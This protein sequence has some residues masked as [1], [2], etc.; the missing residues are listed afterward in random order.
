MKNTFFLSAFVCLGIL[1]AH[2]Q[3]MGRVCSSASLA[4][5]N[6]NIYVPDTGWGTVTDA[7]GEYDLGKIALL[8]DVDTIRF[9]CVGYIGC[10]V[11]LEKLRQDNFVTVLYE[12]TIALH[13]VPVTAD[14]HLQS[15]LA[16]ER[17]ASVPGRGIGA[18]GSCLVGGKI[19]VTGGDETNA[20]VPAPDNP[21]RTGYKRPAFVYEGYNKNMYIY[22]IEKDE[23]MKSPVQFRPRAYH[24]LL[25]YR[26]R[27]YLVGGKSLSTN[28][29]IEWLNNTID[30]YDWK[31]DTLVVDDANPHQAANAAAFIYGDQMIVMG[32]SIKKTASERLYYTDDIHVLDLK[33]GRWYLLGKMPMAME[34]TGVIWQHKIYLFGGSAGKPLDAVWAFDL[35]TLQWAQVAT[36]NEPIGRSALTVVGDEAYILSGGKIIVFDLI[37]L[38]QRDYKIDVGSKNGAIHYANGKLYILG[39]ISDTSTGVAASNAVSSVDLSVFERT[40]VDKP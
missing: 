30:I 25:V 2:A 24:S 4:L 7:A 14:K 31:R 18:F 32:G 3:T 8:Q 17:L 5:E 35:H 28:K 10:T 26:Q 1:G 40:G 16:Y 29:K 6:V 13:E 9:S 19:Y 39:G 38:Q 11:T 15:W 34:S 36:L 23:W 20:D 22:D 37:S 21:G 33:S 27:F 12:D